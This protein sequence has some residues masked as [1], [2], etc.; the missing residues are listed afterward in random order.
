MNN[1]TLNLH[2]TY[3]KLHTLNLKQLKEFRDVL[4]REGLKRGMIDGRLSVVAAR[5]KLVK[6]QKEADR[7]LEGFRKDFE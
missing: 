2:K 1:P 5:L 7:I 6:K 3:K 4:I